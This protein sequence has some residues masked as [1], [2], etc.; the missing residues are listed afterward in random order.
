MSVL[1]MHRSS[2]SVDPVAEVV[3]FGDNGSC[4]PI[5]PAFTDQYDPAP[6]PGHM[7]SHTKSQAPTHSIT[8]SDRTRAPQRPEFE[9]SGQGPASWQL[10]SSPRGRGQVPEAM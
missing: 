7:K 10:A 4:V 5:R 9:T 8:R 2:F 3:V 6:R 1:V